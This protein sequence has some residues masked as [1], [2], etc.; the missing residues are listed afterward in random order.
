MGL[1]HFGGGVGAV[2][3][4]ADRGAEVTV[5]DLATAEQL[6]RPLAE[7]DDVALAAVHLGGH[8]EKDFLSAKLVV[9]NPAVRPGNPFLQIARRSSARL[10]TEIELFIE[11]CPAPII[12]VTGSNGKSTT[13]AMI[14]AVLRADGRPGLLGGN[15]GGS[16]L[17]DLP[18]IGRDDWVVLELSSFQLAHLGQSAVMPHVAVVTN[19][20]PNHLNWHE[21]LAN[22]R[23]AKQRLLAE[24]SP[25][26]MAVLDDSLMKKDG[27]SDCIVGRFLRPLD[28]SELPALQMP[29]EHNLRNA[30]LAAAAAGAAGCSQEAITRGLAS[31]QTLPGR[32][33]LVATVEGRHYYNDTTA[34]TPESTIA[35]VKSLDGGDS[36]TW[37]LAG[38]SDKGVELDEMAAAI[39]DHTRGTAFFGSTAA[40]LQQL[41]ASEPG[42]FS[43]IAAQTLEEAFAWCRET[44]R[45][46]DRILLSPGCASLDQ[47]RN[48]RHR[49]ERFEE[50]VL[51]YAEAPLTNT[52]LFE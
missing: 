42:D 8:C 15:I 36:A 28:W 51:Q 25:R 13:A 34:T 38:G 31:F 14:A 23:T 1:G 11:A 44:S 10:T 52:I 26:D 2:R 29:G 6:A 22:Y 39:V 7:L 37:L 12:A 24:Q 3:W 35:A 20:S 5:T 30:A 18:Q 48:F 4:L 43:S 33:Q 27:W 9:V 17:A 49:G 19:F 32:L 41:C 40:R 46:G 47:F 45:A 50:L 21:S 16:L